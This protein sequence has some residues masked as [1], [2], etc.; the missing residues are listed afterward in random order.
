MIPPLEF[1]PTIS[2]GVFGLFSS[3]SLLTTV[4]LSAHL[5]RVGGTLRRLN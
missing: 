1:A 5:K 4:V 2:V 3:N